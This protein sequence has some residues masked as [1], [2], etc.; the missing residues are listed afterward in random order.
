[1]G[2]DRCV[3]QLVN[4]QFDTVKNMIE[5]VINRNI[6]CSFA[7]RD[8]MATMHP[9]RPLPWIYVMAW[10]AYWILLSILFGYRDERIEWELLTRGAEILIL[11]PATFLHNRYL[12]PQ[13]L[14]RGRVAHYLMTMS[15]SMVVIIFYNT[16][17][18]HVLARL[19]PDPRFVVS[20]WTLFK[21]YY[22]FLC[23]VDVLLALAVASIVALIKHIYVREHREQLQR[24]QL[25]QLRLAHLQTQIQP[26]FFFNTLNNLYGL[27][28]ERSAALPEAI[29]QL[30]TIMDY[31]QSAGRTEAQSLHREIEFFRGYIDLELLRI[32]RKDRVTFLAATRDDVKVPPLIFLP[33]IENAFKHSDKSADDFFISIEIKSEANLITCIVNNSVATLGKRSDGFGLDNLKKRLN[34]IF[35]NQSN[36]NLQV[37]QSPKSHFAKLTFHV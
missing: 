32:R 20:Y 23:M 8:I 30:S 4:N 14:S 13:L 7:C 11:V 2:M 15:A 34:T 19:W 17:A 18:W 5:P 6:A 9:Y 12:L 1:M 31:L 10:L 3:R 22:L 35:T 24:N 26:H 29:L 16:L 28:L 27:S 33:M 25:L 37:I 21:P 36:W